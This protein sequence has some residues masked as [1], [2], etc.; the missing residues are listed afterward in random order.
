MKICF[1]KNV[2]T[3]Y[4]PPVDLSAVCSVLAIIISKKSLKL[5]ENLRPLMQYLFYWRKGSK[6]IL[7]YNFPSFSFS[8]SYIKNSFI[9]M[10]RTKQTA[11]KFTGGKAPRKFRHITFLPS[12]SILLIPG[13][14][15]FIRSFVLLLVVHSS[16]TAAEVVLFM[17]GPGKGSNNP[18][19]TS[20]GGN[21]P[22]IVK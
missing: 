3:W 10:A 14:Y 13:S 7:T 5:K 1:F 15:G 16:R 4:F 12:P 11:R 18:N 22:Y 8:S 17:S 6:K 21:N 20:K 2:W 9:K 19:S